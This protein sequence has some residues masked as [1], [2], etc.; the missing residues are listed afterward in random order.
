MAPAVAYL[1]LCLRGGKTGRGGEKN[2]LACELAI[3]LKGGARYVGVR[4]SKIG[5]SY[6][7]HNV[8]TAE[9]P[10]IDTLQWSHYGTLLFPW[11][12]NL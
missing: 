8:T 12:T 9:L 11:T 6:C 2:Q 10:S 5:V 4:L 1:G 7:V 3:N